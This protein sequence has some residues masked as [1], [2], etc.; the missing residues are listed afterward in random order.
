MSFPS[1]EMVKEIRAQYPE[2]SRVKL[3]CMNDPLTNIPPG[4]LGTV[5]YVDDIG[6]IHTRWDNGS[7]LAVVYGVDHAELVS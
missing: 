1:P 4:T 6:S 7:G 5:R 3:L 2:G